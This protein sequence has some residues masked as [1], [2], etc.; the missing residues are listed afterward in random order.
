MI[1]SLP[2]EGRGDDGEQVKAKYDENHNLDVADC[3]AHFSSRL[4]M[5]GDILR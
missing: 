2:D 5:P 4:F 1:P 3:A